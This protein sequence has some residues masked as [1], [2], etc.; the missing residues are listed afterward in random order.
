ML[1]LASKASSTADEIDKMSIRTGLSSQQLQEL[2]FAASQTGVSFGAVESASTRMT[3]TLR[4]NERAFEQLGVRT[5]DLNGNLR[6]ADELFNETIR[7]LATME[8]EMERNIAGQE[9]FGRGFTEMIPLIAAG[10]DGIEELSARAHEL[11]SV[12]SDEAIAAN[13]KFADTMDEVKT[14]LR[15]AFG[16]IMTALMPA[17][18]GFLNWVLEHMPQIQ[19]VMEK[20][21]IGIQTIVTI[22]FEVFETYVLPVLTRVW[23]WVKQNLPTMQ[24]EFSQRFEQIQRIVQRVL[25]II[26][27]VWDQWGSDILKILGVAFHLILEL[28]DWAL[29]LIEGT[30]DYWLAIMDGDIDAAGEAWIKI[31]DVTWRAFVTIL[32]GLWVAIKA[33]LDTLLRSMRSWFNNLGA[34]ARQWGANMI[35]G[36]IRGIRSK[37]DGVRA[38]TRSVTDAAA[39]FL[40][41]RSPAKEGEGRHITQWGEN[42]VYGFMDGIQKALPQMH[43]LMRDAIPNLGAEISLAGAT[44][45]NSPIT[46]QNMTVRS[47]SDIRSIARELYFLQRSEQRGRGM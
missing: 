17:L 46:I 26:K 34:N 21:M 14:A 47:D 43:E 22:A 15:G 3:G 40:G 10:A 38:A 45:I 20:V 41:F 29:D 24:E 31:W 39:G 2:R 4:T 5:R 35:E 32:G 25:E 12:L 27:R 37:I 33:V 7:A 8:N 11:G 42:M 6:S 18:Q 19:A 44:T 16:E 30:L 9:I 1:G 23:E 13:V 28:F 36:F